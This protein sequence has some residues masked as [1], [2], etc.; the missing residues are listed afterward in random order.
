[1][2]SGTLLHSI[3]QLY[4]KACL[5]SLL[6]LSVIGFI[7]LCGYSVWNSVN[8]ATLKLNQ[9]MILDQKVD[10]YRLQALKVSNE[11]MS[12]HGKLRNNFYQFLQLNQSMM[13]SGDFSVSPNVFDALL[14]VK[15]DINKIY[16]QLIELEKTAGDQSKGLV[17]LLDERSSYHDSLVRLE[18]LINRYSWF[19]Y[20]F[21]WQFDQIAAS[22]VDTINFAK[23][24]DF[25]S[26]IGTYLSEGK[27]NLFMLLTTG[28]KLDAIESDYL[29]QIEVLENI[30]FDEKLSQN[31]VSSYDSIISALKDNKNY[32]MILGFLLLLTYVIQYR[33]FF[34]DLGHLKSQFNHN[35]NFL[36]ERNRVLE[37]ENRRYVSHLESMGSALLEGRAI[38]SSQV[39]GNQSEAMLDYD[40]DELESL[41][42]KQQNL[43]GFDSFHIRLS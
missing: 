23:A 19:V 7:V 9:E 37:I 6:N 42:A 40:E 5:S 3:K 15:A 4:A 33:Y 30:A 36:I 22:T 11:L 28:E 43:P 18:S 12:S 13:N 32:F 25:Q 16:S 29:K 8:S 24:G 21:G 41:L 34:V 20:R 26:S 31:L 14:V 39:L 38:S 2:K 1:M 10:A 17:D 27:S 35:I